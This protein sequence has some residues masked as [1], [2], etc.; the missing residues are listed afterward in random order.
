M[1]GKPDLATAN[2]DL[3]GGRTASVLLNRGDGGFEAEGR[4]RDGQRSAAVALTDLNGDGWLDLVLAAGDDEKITVRL[5]GGDEARSERGGTTSW[6]PR[7][8]WR[9]A[10]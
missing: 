9:R 8:R 4:L 5:N 2:Y 7:P 1:T 10:T 6:A 3:D